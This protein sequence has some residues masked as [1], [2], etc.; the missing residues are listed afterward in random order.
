[1]IYT[2]LSIYLGIVYFLYYSINYV[3]NYLFKYNT[4]FDLYMVIS[5]FLPNILYWILGSL[6]FY[7]DY[8]KKPELLYEFKI[9]KTKSLNLKKIKK[10]FL[11]VIGNQL[12]TIPFSIYILN[13]ISFYRISFDATPLSFLMTILHICF[14]SIIEEILFYY[15]HRLLHTS[16]LYG[17]IHKIH[18]EWT[19]PIGLAA[20]YS[21]PIEHIVSNII[22][23]FIGPFLLKSHITTVWLWLCFAITNTIQTHSGYHLPYLAS[24]EMHDYHHRVFNANYGVFNILDTFHHTNETFK[25]SVRFRMDKLCTSF[26]SVFSTIL[27]QV[28]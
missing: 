11:T 12:F 25:R 24:S 4:N 28:D 8:T 18:H 5:Y 10:L 13:P 16:R 17:S 19:A 7:L 3:F 15:I 1:M 22:P 23:V 20:M 9:Q 2:I 14:F 21:H 6:Y 27:R 26:N